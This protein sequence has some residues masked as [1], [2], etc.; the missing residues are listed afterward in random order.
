MLA[1]EPERDVL[2]MRICAMGS[3][4]FPRASKMLTTSRARFIIDHPPPIPAHWRPRHPLFA[5]C[6]IPRITVVSLFFTAPSTPSTENAEP[7]SVY[8]AQEKE[9]K[10]CVTPPL[11]LYSS[12]APS[13]TR[14][15]LALPTCAGGSKIFKPPTLIRNFPQV[16]CTTSGFGIHTGP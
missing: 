14:S 13:A 15:Q 12:S 2:E 4:E 8:C 5:G 7:A 1:W 9:E 3:E 16:W 6:Q 11:K 10:R